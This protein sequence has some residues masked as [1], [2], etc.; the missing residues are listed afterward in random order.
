MYSTDFE[1]ADKRLSDF[2][3]ITCT[4]DKSA[5]VE[6]INIGCDITFNTVKN[7]HSSIHS[8]TSSAYDNVYTTSFQI[9]KEHCGDNQDEAY[10]TYEEIRNL[11]K[12]LNRL[13]YEKFKP[14]PNDDSYYDVHYFGSFNVD[15]VFV[16][17]RVIGFT[18]HFTAST[19]YGFGED[20]ILEIV[21]SE[22]NEEFYLYG[23]SDEADSVI[24]PKVRIKCLTDGELKITNQT[25][26]NYV[27]V[28]NCKA[29]E[30]IIIDG[31]YKIIISDNEEHTTTTLPRDFNYEY[32][33]IKIGEG[34]DNENL[35]EVS[36]P[37]EITITY[38]PIRKVGV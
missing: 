30:E 36:M 11:Y 5:G 34:N 38:S 14:Y 23:E 37:C 29:N 9:A 22:A 6:E 3:C 33:D 28:N 17:G 19:P 20:T 8:K 13:S 4:I 25:T 32:F 15:E 24:Y 31:E 35:Y 2:G 21:T 16:D 1:Y 12:W 7:N 10:F 27:F 26:G 18:L